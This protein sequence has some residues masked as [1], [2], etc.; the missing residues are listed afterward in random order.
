MKV[1]ESDARKIRVLEE[2]F[3]K[4]EFRA[5]PETVA[6]VFIARA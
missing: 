6:D 2:R 1:S 3:P 4:P 5:N